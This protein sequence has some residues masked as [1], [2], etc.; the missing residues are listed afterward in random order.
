MASPKDFRIPIKGLSE[1]L[2][3]FEFALKTEFFQMVEADQM[4][5][6]DFEVIVDAFKKPNIIQLDVEVS[7]S[8]SR[9]CDTCLARISLHGE[10]NY[11]LFCKYEDNMQDGDEVIVVDAEQAFLDMSQLFYE[12]TVLAL[13]IV[14]RIDCEDMS[15]RPCNEEMLDRLEDDSTMQE[16]E[17]SPWDALK[18]M[19]LDNT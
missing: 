17:A 15:S 14:N 3:R 2:T 19:N 8:V 5:D 9:N 7:G 18:G 6:A 13:P 10:G 16:N 11:R 4:E 12:Y 1:G